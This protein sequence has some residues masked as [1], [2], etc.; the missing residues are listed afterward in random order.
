[1]QERFTSKKQKEGGMNIVDFR[2]SASKT[3]SENKANMPASNKVAEAISLIP[4]YN[5]KSY[6][7]LL[8]DKKIEVLYN[9]LNGFSAVI[10]FL[11]PQGCILNQSAPLPLCELP[12]EIAAEWDLNKIK[13][14]FDKTHL[15]PEKGVDGEYDRVAVRLSANGGGKGQIPFQPGLALGSVVRGDTLIKM[16]QYADAIGE[17]DTIIGQIESAEK[18]ILALEAKIKAQK[19]S[20]SGSTLIKC[21]NN[22]IA[23]IN[24]LIENLVS[25]LD[26]KPMEIPNFGKFHQ[27]VESPFDLEKSTMKVQTR[28]FD[29][30]NY[31]SQYIDMKK[32]SSTIQDSVKHASS[33]GNVSASGGVWIFKANASYAW[34]EATSERL[35]E[36]NREGHAEGVLMINAIMTTRHVRCFTEIQYNKEKLEMILDVMNNQEAGKEDLN[37]CGI[38]VREDGK[39]EIYVL[40]EAVLGGSFTALVT[41]LKEE[42]ADRSLKKQVKESSKEAGAGVSAQGNLKGISLGG[43]IGGSYSNQKGDQS[44]SD[45]LNNLAS[46]RVT[47]EFSALGAMPMLSRE[48]IEQEILKQL[49]LNP[50]KFELS[51]KEEAEVEAIYK[52]EKDANEM[53]VISLKRE[54][55]L[56]NAQLAVV[57]TY[58]GLTAMKEKQ[59]IHTL[60]SVM[61]AYDNFAL[62]MTEDSDCGIPIGFNYQVLS[63]GFLQKTLD[64][65]NGFPQKNDNDKEKI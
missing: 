47:I 26:E 23:A 40:S 38:A 56:Q 9:S 58:R 21:W 35:A 28:G 13:R 43:S 1:M 25:Q 27:A 37:R 17:R 18:R 36:I 42:K 3:L 49:D 10:S 63:Q 29:S 11:N 8:K 61:S 19:E 50:S 33:A 44:E 12:K 55:K 5:V 34:S 39:K 15:I 45:L 7:T 31:S 16:E 53:S 14:F 52:E 54:R 24:K 59:N 32:D 4:F 64:R 6:T 46:T 51:Q 2:I 41:F 30:L 60:Q 57:N 62:K 65:M 22:E 20:K 48:I